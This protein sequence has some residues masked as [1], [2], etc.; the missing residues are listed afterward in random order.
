[1][2]WQNYYLVRSYRGD[3]P[4]A[5][6]PDLAHDAAIAVCETNF[7]WRGTEPGGKEVLRN[8][9]AYMETRRD[10]ESWLRENAT[11][12][13]VRIDK[14]NPVYFGLSREPERIKALGGPEEKFVV[15]RA[16]DV[17]LSNWSFTV[18]DS[19]SNRN[20]VRSGQTVYGEAP[21]PSHGTVMNAAQIAAVI[22]RHGGAHADGTE[23][24]FEAQ[25]WARKPTPTPGARL[26]GV[27]GLV[28]PAVV[29]TAVAAATYLASGSVAEV[30]TAGT[31]ATED[32]ANA[33]SMRHDPA[34]AKTAVGQAAYKAMDYVEE[35]GNRV[36]GINEPASGKTKLSPEQQR[37]SVP[38]AKP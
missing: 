21:H 27:A 4:F 12:A 3:D 22:D 6:V 11:A 8:Q 36:F 35:V 5:V 2:D 15:F 13:G 38:I 9:T 18:D 24:Y 23:R 32:T 19:F 16:S 33:M 20:F 31:G 26:A 37:A 17:D 28:A 14:E 7:P 34:G 25:M 29:G 10:T 30:K 1:M